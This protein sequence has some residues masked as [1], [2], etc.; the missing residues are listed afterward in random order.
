MQTFLIVV[1]GMFVGF[2]LVLYVLYL[3]IRWKLRKVFSGL[4]E[5]FK[6]MAAAMQSLPPAEIKLKPAPTIDWHHPAEVA[7]V[8]DALESVGFI[9]AGT[10]TID[11]DEKMRLRGFAQPHEGAWAVIY[12]HPDKPGPILDVVSEYA[13]GTMTTHSNGDETGLDRPPGKPIVRYPGADAREVHRRHLAERPEGDLK[14]VDAAGFATSVERAYAEEMAWR[15]ERGGLTAAE[16]RAQARISGQE[17]DDATVEQVRMMYLGK[18]NEGL[19]ERLRKAFLRTSG[20][21]AVEWEEMEDRT[22]FIHNRMGDSDVEQ[23]FR[24][25]V[26]W[27]EDGA[28]GEQV[29]RLKRTVETDRPRVAFAAMNEELAFERRFT[30]VGEV[31]EPVAADVYRAPEPL[32]DE[33]DDA[34]EDED[35]A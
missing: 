24:R 35:D 5:A 26:G 33:D 16:V 17:V 9:A 4:G 11:G 13:D 28:V 25:A 27:S 21:T 8:T 7:A 10:Y 19:D 29:A 31:Y 12:D 2:L 14:P 23:V 32:P 30:K 1:A 15:A 18:L 3:V 22:V 6:G 34:D 20:V